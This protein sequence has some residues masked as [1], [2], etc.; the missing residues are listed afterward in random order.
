MW[1]IDGMRIVFGQ[2]NAA[3]PVM[4]LDLKT[5]Q[6]SQLLAPERVFSPRWSPDGRHIA[7]L[8]EDSKKL[9]VLDVATGK[10][11]DWVSEE[12]SIGFL[13][14]SLDSKYLYFDETAV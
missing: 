9:L 5:R 13:T 11:W 8:S 14:W 4:V 1:F 6:V 12:G 7:V 10:W 2:F 3:G